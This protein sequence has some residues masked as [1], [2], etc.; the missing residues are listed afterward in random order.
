MPLVNQEITHRITAPSTAVGQNLSIEKPFTQDA[1]IQSRPALII[2]VNNPRVSIFIGRVSM[3]KIGLSM[4]LA[5]PRINAAIMAAGQ[6]LSTIKPGSKYAT[7]NNAA[8]LSKRRISK[9][10]IFILIN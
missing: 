10:I 8:A 2:K 6:K 3:T 4:A 9:F 7:T 5:M 1:T